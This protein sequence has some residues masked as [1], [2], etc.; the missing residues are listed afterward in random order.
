[1]YYRR[2]HRMTVQHGADWQVV[3]LKMVVLLPKVV[4]TAK[5]ASDSIVL[6]RPKEECIMSRPP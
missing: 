2:K 4:C 5:N 3:F 6:F 1:M